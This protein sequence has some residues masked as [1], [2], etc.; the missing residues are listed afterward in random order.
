[1]VPVVVPV[2]VAAAVSAF[3]VSASVFGL[4]VGSALALPKRPPPRVGA[5]V[6][7][8]PSNPEPKV[9][10]TVKVPAARLPNKLPPCWFENKPP[11]GLVG[12]SS[13]FSSLEGDSKI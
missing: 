6:T 7:F 4:F 3:V 10:G 5:A 13:F 1:M 9:G 2:V 8:P 11:L 12:D